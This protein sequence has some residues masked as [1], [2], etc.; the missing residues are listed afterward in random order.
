MTYFHYLFIILYYKNFDIINSFSFEN[1]FPILL[2]VN[3]IFRYQWNN[4]IS[5]NIFKVK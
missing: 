4:E 3:S 1:V 2:L 5:F